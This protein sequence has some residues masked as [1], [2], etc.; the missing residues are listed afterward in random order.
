MTPA[1]TLRE[2]APADAARRRFI[3]QYGKLALVTP[4]AMYALMSPRRAQAQVTSLGDCY[5]GLNVFASQ[6]CSTTNGNRF[7]VSS[8]AQSAEYDGVTYTDAFT[9]PDGFI[10]APV[11]VPGLPDRWLVSGVP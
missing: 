8:D 10:A 1:E 6:S 5:N 9:R 2:Q 3:E 7:I 4:A 11:T